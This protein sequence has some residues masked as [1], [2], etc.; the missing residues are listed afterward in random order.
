MARGSRW[1]SCHVPAIRPDIERIPPLAVMR[2]VAVVDLLD[3]RSVLGDESIGFDKVRKYVI[4]GSVPPDAPSD[5]ESALP[6]PTCAAHQPVDIRHLIGHVI[7][8]RTIAARERNA[9][10]IGAAA[11][12]IHKV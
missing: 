4:A 7:E 6:E 9:V 8:R 11:D 5:L 10:M 2:L 3:L 12:K 1:R